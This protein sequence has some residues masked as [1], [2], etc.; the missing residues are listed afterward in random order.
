MKLDD[1]GWHYGGTFPADLPPR[2]G[3]THMGVFLAWAVTRD[4]VSDEV[5]EDDEV[6]L[7]RLRRREITG[8]DLVMSLCDEKLVSGDFSE[9]GAAFAAAYYEGD[10]SPGS[11]TYLDD[12]C[13]TVGAAD[14]YRTPDT[15][16][17]FDAVA[18]VVDR[19]LATWR[20]TGRPT[21]V[22]A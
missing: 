9:E 18:S 7:A 17:T 8:T 13:D 6:E 16:E 20:A 21:H 15:W 4:L 10:R 19:R 11:R 1:A 3:A 2:A 12:Y 5:F 14:V 22:L